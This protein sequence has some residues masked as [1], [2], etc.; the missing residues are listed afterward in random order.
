MPLVDPVASVPL[1]QVLFVEAAD[2]PV[3]AILLPSS[4]ICP[5]PHRTD[6]AAQHYQNDYDGASETPC[7]LMSIH[8]SSFPLASGLSRG[9]H[10]GA[11]EG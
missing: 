4:V 3:P 5:T 10:P 9:P 2:V 7:V 6:R 8:D 11:A 1:P